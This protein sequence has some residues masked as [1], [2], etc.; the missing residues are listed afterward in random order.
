M[1]EANGEVS[2]SLDGRSGD[3]RVGSGRRRGED[4]R[5]RSETLDWLER[6]SWLA[7]AVLLIVCGPW[8]FDV[9]CPVIAFT[10]HEIVAKDA[11]SVTV[12][13]EGWKLRECVFLNVQSFSRVSD[14]APKRDAMLYR[15][16]SNSTGRSKPL[17]HI[18]AGT[19]KLWPTAGAHSMI[20][21]ATYSC[22][23]GDWKANK[24]AEVAL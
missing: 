2:A 19:W 13:I 6:K 16:D 15:V 23:A 24:L 17:G 3:R 10:S 18:D 1:V 21:Y 9:I 22:D 4:H 8:L 11:N 12:K 7:W 5:T 20:V 14:D